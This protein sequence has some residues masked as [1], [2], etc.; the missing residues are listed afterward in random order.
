MHKSNTGHKE[1]PLKWHHTLH[2]LGPQI[3]LLVAGYKSEVFKM[4]GSDTTSFKVMKT[5]PCRGT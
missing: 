5:H 3:G 2:D 4:L 1:L